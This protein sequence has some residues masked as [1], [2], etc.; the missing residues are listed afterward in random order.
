MFAH[1]ALG[2]TKTKYKASSNFSNAG[3]SIIIKFLK[4]RLLDEHPEYMISF[5]VL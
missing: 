2:S 1:F 3:L 4:L 5:N